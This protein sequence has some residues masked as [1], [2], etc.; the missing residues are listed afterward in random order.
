MI[1]DCFQGLRSF[2]VGKS[3]VLVFILFCSAPKMLLTARV[4]LVLLVVIGSHSVH[5]TEGS[6]LVG[7]LYA[8]FNQVAW[9][10]M[11]NLFLEPI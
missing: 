11:I 7:S 10:H 3:P 8:I 2:M 6:E 9:F 4:L 5:I 1:Q